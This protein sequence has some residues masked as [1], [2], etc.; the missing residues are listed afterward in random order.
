MVLRIQLK[1]LQTAVEIGD[2]AGAE[3]II[4][5]IG[6]FK[7]HGQCSNNQAEQIA[8]IKI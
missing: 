8:I 6:K 5:V 2:K 7:L 3:G 1:C 4:F